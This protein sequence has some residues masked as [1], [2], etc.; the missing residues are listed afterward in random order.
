[1]NLTRSLLFVP[2]I[3]AAWIEKVRNYDADGYIL[4]LEDSVP[5]H[6][7]E[8]ARE[9]VASALP[10][11]FKQN[12]RIFVR[13]NKDEDGFNRADVEAIVMEGLEGVV[14]PKPEEPEELERL[15]ERISELETERGIQLG[16]IKLLPV[17]ETAKSM[18]FAYEIGSVSRVFAIAGLTAKD[19]DV[20][21]A[22][23]YK[24]SAEG[25]ETLYMRS[26]IVMAAR[27]AGVLPLGGLWQDVHDL[28]G[29]EKAAEFNRQLGF[30]GELILHPSNAAIVNRTY[31][32]SEDE[33]AYYQGMIDAFREAEA[34]GISAIM[35]EGVHIDYAHVKTAEQVLEAYHESLGEKV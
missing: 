34:K 5:S 30:D 7:K 17:L 15:S 2:G 28:E 18:H 4:D 13:I 33:A 24:W 8:Q 23:G 3:K 10:S 27:A 12:K 11:L 9:N 1:M 20:A 25:L 29:L 21:R 19:G 16:S 32:P 6:L 14:L 31:S 35:Y 22:L 26:K